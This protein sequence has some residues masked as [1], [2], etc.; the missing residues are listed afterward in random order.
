MTTHGVGAFAKEADGRAIGQLAKFLCQRMELR[1]I[2]DWVATLPR[3]T[4]RFS[5]STKLWAIFLLVS[6]FPAV[7]STGW[8]RDSLD[9]GRFDDF[10][11]G[12]SFRPWAT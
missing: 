4:A 12:T 9:L 7:S 8:H 1:C 2:G 5:P 11:Q 10:S 6:Q 3:N